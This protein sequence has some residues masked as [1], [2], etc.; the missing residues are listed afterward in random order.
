MPVVY[1]VVGFAVYQLF[2]WQ[3]GKRCVCWP[4]WSICLSCSALS[5]GHAVLM[6]GDVIIVCTAVVVGNV[7]SSR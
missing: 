7:L 5:F 4:I 3:M 2:L 6:T 1:Q